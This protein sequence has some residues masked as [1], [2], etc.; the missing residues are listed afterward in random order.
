MKIV[1][2][3]AKSLDFDTALPLQKHT[4]P[5]FLEE[6]KEIQQELMNQSPDALS[7]LMSISQKLADLNWQRNQ[8]RKFNTK[9]TDTSR[10]AIFTLDGDVY[11]GL[12]AYSLSEEKIVGL[13]DSLRILSGLYGILRPLD[14]MEAY[15]LEMG[16]TLPVGHNKNLY[17]FWKPKITAALNK[18]LK[19][20][21]LFI[22]LASVEYFSAIDTK[23]LKVPVIKPE[24]KDYKNGDLKI[25]AIY[26]KKARGMMVRFIADS[27]AQTVDDLKHFDYDGYGFDSKLST[28][29]DL[30][31][32]R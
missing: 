8:D 18:E 22:N 12:D 5:I 27:N 17:E 31:F 13:Q 1:L 2:S 29:T 14:V 10:Q 32:T 25:I 11:K 3:P 4:K 28:D 7:K 30:V 21:E 6:A 23:A 15:R 26:A 19:K 20:D 9:I 16:I 24:F